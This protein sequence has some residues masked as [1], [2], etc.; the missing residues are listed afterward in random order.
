MLA[1]II[2]SLSGLAWL[3][4]VGG[5]SFGPF[6]SLL[7]VP[8]VV[9]AATIGHRF[10]VALA[11][12][13]IGS[14]SIIGAIEGFYGPHHAMAGILAWIA[15]AILLSAPWLLA[16]NARGVLSALFIISLPPL[17]LIGWLS[18]VTAVG[19]LYPDLGWVG[20]A[21]TVAMMMITP[22]VIKTPSRNNVPPL[23]M[24]LVMAGIA[25]LM[26]Q[27][28]S[29]PSGW[30]GIDTSIHPSGGDVLASIRNN[31]AAI[32]SALTRGRGAKVLVFP[33]AVID[34]WLPGTQR[35]FADAAQPGQTWLIGA[36]TSR[37]NSVV[38]IAYGK[39]NV[40]TDAAAIL[41]GGN[42]QP[43]SDYSLHPAWWQKIAVI[44]GKRVWISIC[45]EQVLPWTWFEALLE[46]PD[47][48][49]AISNQWWAD[50]A[51]SAPRIQRDSTYAW[52]RLL[53]VPIISAINR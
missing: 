8:A 7:L 50:T 4:P 2:S 47:M 22:S 20:I 19:V 38:S 18:P 36:Q 46:K 35:Q 13:L 3:V 37:F 42:W 53:G 43:W 44:N 15:T 26:Y 31:Q 39:I 24:L 17:G 28:P 5:S 33:E 11:Y 51:S 52:A 49:L 45:V 6:L 21:F 34:Q 40:V 9:S 14:V 48:V 32:N 16:S 25:N 12:Y 27:A 10:A 41:P 30:A 29:I 23:V 1:I